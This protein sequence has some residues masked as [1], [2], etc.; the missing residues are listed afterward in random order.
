MGEIV[1]DKAEQNTTNEKRLR[2][3]GT[4]YKS[5][6]PQNNQD[7]TKSQPGQIFEES[8]QSISSMTK[9]MQEAAKIVSSMKTELEE[10]RSRIADLLA[11]GDPLSNPFK[12]QVEPQRVVKHKKDVETNKTQNKQNS[13]NPV[14]EMIFAKLD[15]IMEQNKEIIRL[16]NS[17]PSAKTTFS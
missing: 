1:S 2:L 16:L 4:E 8:T 9:D 6:E 12:T 11:S 10:K 3:I 14:Y 15:I 7:Q 17:K 5:E 13:S